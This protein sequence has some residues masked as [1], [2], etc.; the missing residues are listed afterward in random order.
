MAKITGIAWCDHTFNP[1]W[2]CVKIAPECANCYAEKWDK[3]TGG[4]HWG[5][6]SER[7]F[8]GLS[9]W[10]EPV[11]WNA[12]AVRDGVR[13]RV[14]CAS[15][16]D[17]F[18]DHP[19]VKDARKSLWE[20]ISKTPGLDWLLLT[21]RPENIDT[22]MPGYFS[23]VWLGTTA[24]TQAMANKN[25][26]ELLSQSAAVRFLSCEPLLEPIDFMQVPITYE[27]RWSRQKLD[28]VIVGCESGSKA[29]S[30]NEDWVRSIRD[31]CAAAKVAFFYKQAM[32][33][34][35]LVST[36]ELDGRM[37]TEFPEVDH[38]RTI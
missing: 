23:N 16:A 12:E 19:M 17:V 33:G 4:E 8:F 30:M 1:W 3:R 25:I 11:R 31:D 18:E 20:L 32:R 28:W 36:P 7:R 27:Q 6:N 34:K 24:G 15:M 37:W 13:R 35:I 2:G 22:M 5:P 10:K 21:K 9:H 29:R 38:A 14:F 26:P